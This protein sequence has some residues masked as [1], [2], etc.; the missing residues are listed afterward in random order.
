MPRVIEVKK[1][2]KDYPDIEVKK[3]EPYFWW[4]FNFG[5]KVRSKTYPK[6]SQLTTSDFLGQLYDIQ[7]ANY[8]TVHEAFEDELQE[9]VGELQNLLDETQERLDAMPEQLQDSSDS[10]NTLTERV[11]AL[12]NAISEL[13][14]IDCD[15]EPDD[16]DVKAE[17]D[18]SENPDDTIKRIKDDMWRQA[19]E[20]K[21]DEAESALSDMNC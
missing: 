21:V 18:E 7:D 11:D 9:V 4:K 10:G 15:I 3:G 8:F 16:E 17:F 6:R 1:A 13:E 19:W 12:E 20:E 5:P 2:R 14:S